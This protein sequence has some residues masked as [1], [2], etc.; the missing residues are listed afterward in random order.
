MVGTIKRASKKTIIGKRAPAS[1][2][3]NNLKQVL[4]GYCIRELEWSFSPLEV[5]FGI[6]PKGRK[7]IYP[8]SLTAGEVVRRELELMASMGKRAARV[9][10]QTE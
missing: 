1:E 3:E 8:S 6:L 10:R 9:V 7:G 5:M 2:W 4:F